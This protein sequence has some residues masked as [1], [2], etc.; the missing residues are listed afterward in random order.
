MLSIPGIDNAN[1]MLTPIF[2]GMENTRYCFGAVSAAAPAFSLQLRSVSMC[3]AVTA[4]L[5][6]RQPARAA[7][8]P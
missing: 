4:G 3:G 8:P 1:A 5:W 6:L 2:S 7:L